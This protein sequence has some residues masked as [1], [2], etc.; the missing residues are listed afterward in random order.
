MSKDKHY[1]CNKHNLGFLFQAKVQTVKDFI[2]YFVKPQSTHS[3]LVE[4]SAEV[5]FCSK[6]P[7]NLNDQLVV[8]YLSS[9]LDVG[10]QKRGEKMKIIFDAIIH[11]QKL[12]EK[13]QKLAEKELEIENLL[14]ALGI[15]QINVAQL[16]L[17]AANPLSTS[18]GVSCSELSGAA[19]LQRSEAPTELRT[20]QQQRATKSKIQSLRKKL[21]R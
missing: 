12:A 5:L 9:I 7:P 10:C 21:D 1:T 13:D 16:S 6:F 2:K 20:D 4:S 8:K 15:A 14:R 3:S 11:D 17:T 18:V 19:G